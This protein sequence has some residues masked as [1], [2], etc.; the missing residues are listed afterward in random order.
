M[1]PRK[2]KPE[3]WYKAPPKDSPEGTENPK[4]SLT[5]YINASATIGLGGNSIEERLGQ[6]QILLKHI[7]RNLSFIS[8]VILV[9]LIWGFLAAALS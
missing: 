9:G 1:K 8:T 4:S 5:D 7:S 6:I 3:R 2:P